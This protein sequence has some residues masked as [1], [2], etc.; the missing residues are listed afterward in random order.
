M[1]SGSASETECHVLRDLITV[2]I[3]D[4]ANASDRLGS[5]PLDPVSLNEILGG[6]L[7]G[8]SLEQLVTMVGVFSIDGDPHAVAAQLRADNVEASPVHA[9][10]AM[11]HIRLMPGIP[12]S[13][14]IVNTEPDLE[15]VDPVQF[16]GVVDSGVTSPRYRP[17]WLAGGLMAR[18]E[19]EEPPE[20]PPGT[21]PPWASHGSFI[22]GLIREIAPEHTVAV[23]RARARP[24]SRFYPPL[25]SSHEPGDDPTT[26]L[27]VLE[28]TIRLVNRLN[29]AD[30]EVTALNMSLGAHACD[31]KD[32]SLVALKAA[33]RLWKDNFPDAP[34]FAA[35]GNTKD[36]RKVFPAAY[37]KVRG[38]AAAADGS[39]A[40]VVWDR[41]HS[42]IE[43][44]NRSWITDVAPGVDLIGTSGLAGEWVTWSGSSFA[45]AVACALYAKGEEPEKD[46]GLRYWPDRNVTY[47]DVD[48]LRF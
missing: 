11:N 44:S 25:D 27:D 43:P 33:V 13:R 37:K 8:G 5:E 15:R 48:A 20:F 36:K 16:I 6:D 4:V 41:A 35:G 31:R 14:A 34:I 12:A 10:G 30:G 39:G 40:Q 19:D 3:E 22:A 42:P 21:E 9:I 1:S 45:T 38:V 28:A 7:E 26:E 23:V 2:R 18:P 46:G 24:I 29:S 32:P 17:D 47:S